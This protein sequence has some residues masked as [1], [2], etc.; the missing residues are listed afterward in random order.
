MTI[1]ILM[2]MFGQL[3]LL[4]AEAPPQA[5]VLDESAAAIGVRPPAQLSLA[6]P[7]EELKGVRPPGPPPPLP[8][9][10][11]RGCLETGL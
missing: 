4:L 1:S 2:N 8:R 7:P 9:P 6:G 3:Y 11:D 5:G 10:M